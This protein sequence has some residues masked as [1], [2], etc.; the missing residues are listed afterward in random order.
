MSTVGELASVIRSRVLDDRRH[1][2]WNMLTPPICAVRHLLLD[3]FKV[4]SLDTASLRRY[5]PNCDEQQLG[6]CGSAHT[7]ASG[8]EFAARLMHARSQN[9]A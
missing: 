1:S 7:A 3:H 5:S 9:R 8:D 6:A 2:R 4:E